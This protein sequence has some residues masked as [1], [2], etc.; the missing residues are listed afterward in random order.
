M[1][2][3]FKFTLKKSEHRLFSKQKPL[4]LLA[5]DFEL[6]PISIKIHFCN[7]PWLPFGSKEESICQV[8]GMILMSLEEA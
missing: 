6:W 7:K 8:L 2:F 1:E 3:K 5:F 4:L